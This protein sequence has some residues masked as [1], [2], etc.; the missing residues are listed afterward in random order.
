MGN[1]LDT[2]TQNTQTDA[3]HS[4]TQKEQFICVSILTI[5]QLAEAQQ[6]KTRNL[7]KQAITFLPGQLIHEK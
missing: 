3:G 6:R 7:F 2:E 4:Q 5:I 1:F